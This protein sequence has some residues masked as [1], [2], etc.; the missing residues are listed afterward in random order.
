MAAVCYKKLMSEIFGPQLDEQNPIADIDGL[1]KAVEAALATLTPEQ[2]A[3]VK[4]VCFDGKEADKQAYAMAL[5]SLKHP[6]C[7]RTLRA[8]LNFKED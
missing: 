8:Y 2:Q 1:T 5:R 7:S 4:A 6:S 3:A